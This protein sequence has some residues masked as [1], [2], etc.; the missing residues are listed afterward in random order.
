MV[1]AGC[2]HRRAAGLGRVGAGMGR[3]APVE[4]GPDPERAFGTAMGRATLGDLVLITGSVF[5]VGRAIG[6]FNNR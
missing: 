3:Y 6:Y 5:L 1:V 4:V 2:G